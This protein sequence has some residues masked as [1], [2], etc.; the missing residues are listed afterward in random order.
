MNSNIVHNNILRFK[1]IEVDIDEFERI[2]KDE[3]TP[4]NPIRVWWRKDDGSQSIHKMY[5][6]D[7]PIGDGIAGGTDTKELMNQYNVPVV[8]TD[9]TWRTLSMDTVEKFIFNKKTYKIK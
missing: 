7:G 4:S 8:D 1:T 5:W 6:I 2:L 9:G 3:A